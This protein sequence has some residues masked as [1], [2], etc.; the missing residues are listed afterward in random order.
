M[1]K[2]VINS[3]FGGFGLSKQ[4]Y[5]ELGIP[6]DGYGYDYNAD[7][8][9]ADP[10]LVAVVEKLGDDANGNHAR[11]RVVDVPDGVNWRIEEYDGREKIAEEHR[12]WG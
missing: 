5:D 7:K 9:R 2:V 10:Q 6:W 11:L 4:A 12:I 1:P 8:K 3:C